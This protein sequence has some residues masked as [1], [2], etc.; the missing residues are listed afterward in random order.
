MVGEAPSSSKLKPSAHVGSSIVIISCEPTVFRRRKHGTAH[1]SVAGAGDVERAL[2]AR[3]VSMSEPG[4]PP[5]FH[6]GRRRFGP[7]ISTA[8]HCE[9]DRER[10]AGG[11]RS[12]VTEADRDAE[13][14]RRLHRLFHGR[15]GSSLSVVSTSSSHLASRAEPGTSGNGATLLSMFESSP[16]RFMPPRSTP[17]SRPPPGASPSI[18]RAACD[19]SATEALSPVSTEDLELPGGDGGSSCLSGCCTAGEARTTSAIA[20]AST[21]VGPKALQTSPSPKR[22]S[23]QALLISTEGDR[24]PSFKGGASSPLDAALEV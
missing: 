10:F 3:L 21:S 5:S 24:M 16:P 11:T 13:D 1:R 2:P 4:G 23:T 19:C 18:P 20:E 22:L 7:A 14:G 8:E 6:P 12:C 17:E 9:R 15:T